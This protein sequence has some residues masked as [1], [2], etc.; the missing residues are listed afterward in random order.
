MLGNRDGNRE[1]QFECDVGGQ[2]R[3]DLQLRLVY[4]TIR[5]SYIA[6]GHDYR[7]LDAGHQQIRDGHG[8]GESDAADE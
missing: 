8:D 2:R 7:N 4:C 1:L 6:A 3:H 5:R